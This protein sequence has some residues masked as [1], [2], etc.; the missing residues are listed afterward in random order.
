M[1]WNFEYV[2]PKICRHHKVNYVKAFKYAKAMEQG[3]RFPPVH[4]HVDSKGVYWVC[5]G[6][7][8][9]M[10]AKLTG[11]DLFIKVTSQY[12]TVERRVPTV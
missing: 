10:A 9:T 12:P 4:V 6:A 5:D 8:R 7:H 2:D 3:D 11:Q 1:K